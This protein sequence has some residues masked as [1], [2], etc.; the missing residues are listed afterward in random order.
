MF[1]LSFLIIILIIYYLIVYYK[2]VSRL[3]KGPTPLPLIGNALQIDAGEIN[4]SLANFSKTYGDVFTVYIPRP[5]VFIMNYD[6][7]KDAF[8][9]RGDDFIGR[10]GMFPDTLFQSTPNGGVIFSE[11]IKWKENRRISLQIL[12]DFGM[13]KNLMEEL[14]KDCFFDM[15]KYIRE[16]PNRKNGVNLRMPL[17]VK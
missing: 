12:R 14:V 6:L 7:I 8:T 16:M 4:K 10:S 11:G 15:D 13:G 5:V 17:Q 2:N 3:P 1:P 9:T